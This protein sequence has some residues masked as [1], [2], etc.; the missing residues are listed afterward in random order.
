MGDWG[1]LSMAMPETVQSVVRCQ[2]NGPLVAAAAQLWIRPD[3]LVVDVTYGRGL[4]WTRF[5]PER[6]VM[7]DL[8]LDGVDFRQLPE[9]D[10]SVDVLV[11]DPP[12]IHTSG[13][14]SAT[15]EFSERYGLV[16]GPRDADE[17][18]DLYAGGIKEAARV[19]RPG[20]RVLV[21]CMD[22]IF[23]HQ[24]LPM[25]Q[26]VVATATTLGLRQADEFVHYS[27][28][29][30]GVWERQQHSRRVHSYLCVFQVPKSRRV[31]HNDGEGAS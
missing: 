24:F 3:D 30:P 26:F 2:E 23:N 20:G 12:Y 11:F 14:T 10:E 29:G 25:R 19:L 27:G 1:Q 17:I 7:H 5:R 9:A 28:S 18:R 21:K 31:I 13:E 4:F 15:G 22:Y 16:H 6:L 8:A